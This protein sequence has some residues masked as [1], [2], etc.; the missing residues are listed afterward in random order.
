MGGHAESFRAFG[1]PTAR[2][3]DGQ[4][5]TAAVAPFAEGIA[6]DKAENQTQVAAG[7]QAGKGE[8]EEERQSSGLVLALNHSEALVSFKNTCCSIDSDVI[9]ERL[10][11]LSVS[12]HP[13]CVWRPCGVQPGSHTAETVIHSLA[14]I[15]IPRSLPPHR[16][17]VPMTR[18]F[19]WTRPPPPRPARNDPWTS[20]PCAMRACVSESALIAFRFGRSFGGRVVDWMHCGDGP[21]GGKRRG[22]NKRS[23]S[24]DW[25]HPHHK[26]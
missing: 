12:T 8:G 1:A 6:E 20:L 18:S 11:P 26:S 23:D 19:D 21:L 3:N 2:S 7:G 14:A 16:S 4:A 25:P 22:R 15:R 5:N 17:A 9:S 24:G 13:C 10:S